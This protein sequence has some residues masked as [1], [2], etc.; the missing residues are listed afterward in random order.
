MYLLILIWMI[1]LALDSIP[2]VSCNHSDKIKFVA[3]ANG[4]ASSNSVSTITNIK[5]PSSNRALRHCTDIGHVLVDYYNETEQIFQCLPLSCNLSIDGYLP[6]G[7]DCSEGYSYFVIPG[8]WYSNGFEQYTDNCPQG[9]C[10]STFDL[11]YSIESAVNDSYPICNNQC[12]SY[13]TGLACGECG[14]DNFIAHD[15]T[16]CV[17]S[18]KCHLKN[19][20]GVILFFFISLLYWIMV[21][22]F[23]FVL[24]HFKFD[25]TAG[26]AYGMIFFYSIL[27]Q[28]VNDNS[29]SSFLTTYLS[30][31]SSIG[32]M[33]PP[34]QF[35]KLWFW[36]KAR[37]ID[38]MF[39]TFFHPVIVTCLIVAIFI[40]GRNSVRIARYIWRYLNSKSICILLMLSYSSISYTSVQ[41]FRSLPIYKR[42]FEGDYSLSE[43]RSYLSPMV[44]YFHD[45]HL[46]YSLVAILC[47]VVIGIGFPFILLLQPYLTR[48]LNINFTSIKPVIDHLKG[49]Y[50]KEYW[51]FAAY[52]LIC[53]QLLYAGDIFTDFLPF[54]KFPIM[55]SI[56]ILIM[57]VHVWLQPYKQN[58]LNVLDSFI[59]MILMLIVIGEH[60]S[61]SSTLVLWIIP[62][63]LFINC[64]T[65]YTR[66]KYLLIPI[67]CLGLMIL[68][69]LAL[70]PLF[71]NWTDYSFFYINLMLGLIS[72][73]ALSSF[74][75][76]VLWTIFH[77]KPDH[78]RLINE[79]ELQDSDGDETQYNE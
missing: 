19:S 58:I 75:S 33:K 45:N 5:F 18:Y 54:M 34:F 32:N 68:S 23:I 4:F 55:L 30:I 22:S 38:H 14:E 12:A 11:Y 50:K 6:I 79:D 2:P 21:I 13:W 40:S 25:I 42:D 71:L 36:K 46:I 43:W 49:C 37:M 78:E 41:L 60:T 62:L 63:V 70:S 61:K 15:S 59:L 28:T 29:Y 77:K 74:L 17:P 8:Y 52:Y 67:S 3:I 69:G 24:L 65:L 39:V 57:M 44:K 27:E 47:E 35:L 31:L 1:T 56:Y 9:H 7:I 66:L 10:N 26:Y 76:Y 72:F 53:R 20:A 48:Y 51:W 73:I 64:I 16:N